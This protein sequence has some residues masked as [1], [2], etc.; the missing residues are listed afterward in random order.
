M[1]GPR[2]RVIVKWT[3]AAVASLRKLPP[4]VRRG[5]LEKADELQSCPDPERVH[6]ALVG[7]L[8]GHYRIVYSRYRA[9]YKVERD[10]L[11]SGDV[12]ETITVIFVIAGIRKEHSKDDVYNLAKRLFQFGVVKIEPDT[13]DDE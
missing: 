5:L 7:P 1:I 9:V 8:A 10:E 2:K 11:S 6:K 12:L 3:P 13:S 4:K